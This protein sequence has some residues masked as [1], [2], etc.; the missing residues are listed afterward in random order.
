MPPVYQQQAQAV[1][2]EARAH[3]K[4]RG[5]QLNIFSVPGV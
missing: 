2:A 5:C 4:K 1:I 3:A